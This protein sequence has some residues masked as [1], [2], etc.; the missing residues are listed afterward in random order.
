METV[1]AA[2]EKE[3]VKKPPKLNPNDWDVWEQTLI[4]CLVSA[5]GST[6]MPLN[7]IARDPN[8]TPN[9]FDVA[10]K[11][12]RF[13]CSVALSGVSRDAGNQ[14]VSRELLSFLAGTQAEPFAQ[15]AR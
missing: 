10:D 1:E 6:G 5:R 11:V 15:A 2:E 7:C 4:D 13:T 14:R 12:N 3:G 9:D 8:L